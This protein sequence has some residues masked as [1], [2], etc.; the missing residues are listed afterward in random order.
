MIE[1]C[2]SYEKLR[3]STCH[4][5]NS[6]LKEEEAARASALYGSTSSYLHDPNDSIKLCARLDQESSPVYKKS[7]N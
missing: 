5:P 6:T 7:W 3:S 1:S 2:K 4:D